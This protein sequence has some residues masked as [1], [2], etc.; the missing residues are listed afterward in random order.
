MNKPTLQ[1]KIEK[2]RNEL[3]QLY[4]SEESILSKKLLEK[5]RELDKLILID[6]KRKLN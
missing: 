5:S 6:Q 4:R 3:H 2:L 1:L